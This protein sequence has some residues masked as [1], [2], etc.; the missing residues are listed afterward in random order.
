M[1][2]IICIQPDPPRFDSLPA[3]KI[4]HYPLEKRAYK[5]FAQARV[6]LTPSRFILRLWAFEAEPR[7]LSRLEGVFAARQGATLLTVEALAGGDWSC[8]AKGP[9]GERPLDAILHPLAGEDLQGIFWGVEAEIPRQAA[10]RALGCG[11]LVPGS[12][13]LGNFFK[14]SRDPEKPHDGSVWP[15]DFAAGREYALSSLAPFRVVPW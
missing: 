15:A 9:E 3:W 7:P 5:P 10:E 13:L 4:T 8:T 2:A 11:S 1:E 14:R 12:V 6:T